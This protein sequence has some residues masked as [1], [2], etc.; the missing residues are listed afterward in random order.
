MLILDIDRLLG[1]ITL[2]VPDLPLAMREAPEHGT[3]TDT[4]KEG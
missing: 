2:P 4:M 1:D 3:H